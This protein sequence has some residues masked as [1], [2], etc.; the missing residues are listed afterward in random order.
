MGY[1][2]QEDPTAFT[3]NSFIQKSDNTCV[4]VDIIITR[5]DE[6]EKESLGK[7]FELMKLGKLNTSL[8]L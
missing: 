5:H 7:N 1:N 8:E 2:H 4:Y 6:E 3:I